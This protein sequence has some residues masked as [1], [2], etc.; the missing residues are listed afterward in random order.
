VDLPEG[1][2]PTVHV[3]P[4]E[5]LLDLVVAHDDRPL[6]EPRSP[7]DR[8]PGN[9]R[10]FSVLMTAMLQAHDVPARARCGF[11]GYFLDGRFEDHWVCEYWNAAEGRW[12]LVDAQ[13]DNPQLDFFPIDF[14]VTDVPRDRFLAG[15]A[16][17]E[18]CRRGDG[19]PDT[20]G[21]T[22]LDESGAWWIA[23]NLVRD[24]AALGKVELLPW[25]VWGVMPEPG[26]VIDDE[27]TALL[28]RLA[29]LT[30]EPDETLGELHE[31]CATDERVRVPPAVRNAPRG[32]D[33]AV[34]G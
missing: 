19:D 34:S 11:G 29:E 10:T 22:M 32:R 17:W 13:I 2:H 24:A 6:V 28:D 12:V 5:A 31:L 33:E 1:E 26:D 3:R 30:R 8:I 7:V 14:D 25:D 16:A 4:V 27:L 15:G 9:C 21:L 23:G 20:F 18:R